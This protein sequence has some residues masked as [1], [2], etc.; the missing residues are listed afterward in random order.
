M[1]IYIYTY[2]YIGRFQELAAIISEIPKN[3]IKEKDSRA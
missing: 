1:Y 2:A 3:E